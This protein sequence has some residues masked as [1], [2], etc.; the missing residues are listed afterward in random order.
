MREHFFSVCEK[1]LSHSQNEKKMKEGM[2]EMNSINSFAEKVALVTGGGTGI[3]RAT[4]L[5]FAQQGAQVVVAGRRASEGEET[6]RQIQEAGGKG[7]FIQADVTD[8][9]SVKALIDAIV[10]GYGHLDAAFNNAGKAAPFA[11]LFELA[12]ETFDDTINANL[13]SVWLCM[14][15]EIPQM[16]KQGRGSIVNN[17]SCLGHVGIANMALYSATKHGIIGLTRSAALEN[18]MQN[19]RINAVSPGSIDTPMGERAF[20]SAESHR[21]TMAAVHPV[22]RIGLPHEVAEAVLFLSSEGASFIT[23]Q[24]LGVDGGYTAQ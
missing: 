13:K 10:E 17:A 24:S 9:A 22:G 6:V 19:V 7:R 11:P 20:G 3:G 14:K 15:Y 21:Q 23:G 4:A 18:A 8:E 1:R 5:A 12:A 2:E 16:L